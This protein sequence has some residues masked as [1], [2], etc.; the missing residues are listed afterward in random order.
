MLTLALIMN[1]KE[2]KKKKLK[3][4]IKK[5]RNWLTKNKVFFE[6]FSFLFLGFFVSLCK[7]NVL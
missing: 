6:V 7:I 4:K 2:I 3:K 1:E 5:T